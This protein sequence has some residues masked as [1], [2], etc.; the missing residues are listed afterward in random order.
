M[1][2]STRARPSSP[3]CTRARCTCGRHGTWP[4]CIARSA[5]SAAGAGG[6]IGP[7]S[8]RRHR[9]PPVAGGPRLLSHAHGRRLAGSGPRPSGR[10]PVR[11]GGQRGGP[12]GRPR[13]R[14]AH[15]ARDG[16]RARTTAALPDVDGVG[17]PP[18]PVPVGVL[19]PSDPARGVHV[20]ERRRVGLVRRPPAPGRVRAGT[21]GSRPPRARAHRRRRPCARAAST[22]GIRA[23]GR[24]R[25]AR[26]TP[27]APGA[28]RGDLLRPLRRRCAEASTISTSGWPRVSGRVRV[29]EPST[30]TTVAY[31]YSCD[32]S[33][34][35]SRCA[36]RPAGAT[37][38]RSRSAAGGRTAGAS[39][40]ER[41]SGA[42][43]TI[44]TVGDDSYA[45]LRP[46]GR[47]PAGDRAAV[48]PRRV[49]EPASSLSA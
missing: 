3:P 13:R 11:D 21:G 26:A 10:R 28:G 33:G 40:L 2:T 48:R 20:P 29:F 5:T 32:P 1:I 27:A 36:T 18:A 47:P 4:G 12:S 35:A 9:A 43:V 39:R 23:T 19:P 8:S 38:A 6:T 16:G 7:G 44:R 15:A 22:S 42:A 31:E 45:R 49:A 34:G 37:G 17:G 24:A 41:R 46:T 25:A 30:G 14:G